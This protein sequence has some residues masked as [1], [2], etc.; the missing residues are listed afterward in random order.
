LLTQKA[1][2]RVFYEIEAPLIPVL[3]DMEFE[4]VKVDADVLRDFA[5]Q[6]AKEMADHEKTIHRLAGTPFN[7]NSPRQL[8]QILFE[9][10]KIGDAPKKTKT[11]QYSTD[12]QT[13]L[14]L[15]PDH[16]VV[17]RLMEH[18]TAAK[19]KSTYADALP[20]A[21]WPRTARIHTTFN[22]VAT[23]TGRLN[24]QDP[25]LQN[26]P[27]RR[28]R[29]QEIRRAFVPREKGFCLLSADYSQ[30]ELRIIAALSHESGLLEAFRTGG[31]VHT[32]TAARVFGV[33][34]EMVTPEMR[35]KAK[36]VNYGIAY[37]ISAFGLAQRL[38]IPRKEAGEIIDQYFAQFPGIRRYM[39]DTITFAREHEYVE[40][41][42]GRRRYIRDIR[43]QNMT[44]RNGAERN[45]INAPIQGTAADMI[46]IAMVNIHREILKR[47]LR[48][49]M[50]LQVHDELVFDVYQPERAEVM[51]LV[52][53]KMRTAIPL[54]VPIV[55]EMGTGLNWLE[56]H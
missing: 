29:G 34:P 3:A 21:I 20:D 30:I 45:A 33:F 24:S 2:E 53:Q 4:G 54:E 25:N 40:T 10:L 55:V 14:A 18:R 15:A 28:E 5:A 9:V 50:V 48:T 42:T 46:K 17:R 27:I 1:Q 36:M 32:A 41:V 56:A 35:R 7:L 44:V 22:Q 6:L 49:R 26:I 12:E 51:P 13:L 23:T 11:G 19:L 43:S 37:G 39:D 8:G 52:E 47:G 16:E 38:G 31:D